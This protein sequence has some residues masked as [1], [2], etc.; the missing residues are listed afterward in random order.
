MPDSHGEEPTY[1]TPR[2]ARHVESD[3][4]T[5]TLASPDALRRARAGRM[6]QRDLASAARCHPSMIGHLESGKRDTVAVTLAEAITEA[7]KVKGAGVEF[8]DLWKTAH[9]DGGH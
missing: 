7:L 3:G 8:A 4:E 1:E 9:E 2:W 6:N 5:V